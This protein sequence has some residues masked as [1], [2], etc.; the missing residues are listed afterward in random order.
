M[1]E[2]MNG[3]QYVMSDIEWYVF[4]KSYIIINHYCLL[5]LIC[6]HSNGSEWHTCIQLL[7]T[8]VLYPLYQTP[9]LVSICVLCCL[10]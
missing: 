8:S 9:V 2:W 4:V 1:N 7:T 3:C 5:L 6:K 10:L